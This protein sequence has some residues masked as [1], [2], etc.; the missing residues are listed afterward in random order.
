MG[1]GDARCASDTPALDSAQTC[2]EE[3]TYC[4]TVMEA[5]WLSDG[6]QQYRIVRG[7]SAQPEWETC[8]EF[9][10]GDSQFLIKGKQV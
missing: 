8:P 4:R 6:H 9:A 7:C 5:D 3:E 2:S 10:S 1:Y